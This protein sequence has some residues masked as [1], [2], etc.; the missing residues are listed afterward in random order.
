MTATP[1]PTPAP[2]SREVQGYL[3]HLAAK[4]AEIERLRAEVADARRLGR[5]E[6]LRELRGIV[7]AKVDELERNGRMRREQ[8]APIAYVSPQLADAIANDPEMADAIRD[9]TKAAGRAMDEQRWKSGGVS[10]EPSMLAALHGAAQE[11]K[12]QID[13]GLWRLLKRLTGGAP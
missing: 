11:P 9:V 5:E 3:D 6:A 4:N 12:L 13:E 1:D 8:P 7:D 10:N 2:L